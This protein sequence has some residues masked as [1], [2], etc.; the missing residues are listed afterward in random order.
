MARWLGGETAIDDFS[1]VAKYATLIRHGQLA[2]KVRD[3]TFTGNVFETLQ[4][5]DRIGGDFAWD[6]SSGECGKGPE[7]LPVCDGG[8]HIRIQDVLVG[9]K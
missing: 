1:F 5:I 6:E 4:H 2:E 3:V 9:G 8:P 7:G